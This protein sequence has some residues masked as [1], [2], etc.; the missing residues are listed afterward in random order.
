[1]VQQAH[2]EHPNGRITVE[3]QIQDSNVTNFE[4]IIDEL[5]MGWFFQFF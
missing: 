1:M 5:N 2:S 3:Q 4:S